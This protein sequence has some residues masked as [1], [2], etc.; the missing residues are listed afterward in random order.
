[1]AT[2]HFTV[3]DPPAKG[4]PFLAVGVI[5]SDVIFAKAAKT[6]AK[7]EALLEE[8]R[9]AFESHLKLTRRFVRKEDAEAK[10]PQR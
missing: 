1:M 8:Q 7:A 9:A 10:R 4:V 5:G 3:Y 6:R 2:F